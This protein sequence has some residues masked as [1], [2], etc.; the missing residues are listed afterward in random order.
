MD[1]RKT[2]VNYVAGDLLHGNGYSIEDALGRNAN[3]NL[4][5]TGSGASLSASKTIGVSDVHPTIESVEADLPAGE[6]GSGDEANFILTFDREISVA[7]IPKLPL[8]IRSS[9][10]A[11][12]VDGSGT[13]RLKFL[14]KVLPGDDVERLDISECTGAELL[15][16]SGDSIV[17]LINA[18]RASP[19]PA[20]TKIEGRTIYQRIAIDTTPPYVKGITPQAST[21]PSGTY[22]V[23]DKLFFE[24]IRKY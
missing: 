15:L 12:F 17:L 14:F 16:G 22:T 13:K 6:Y 2:E 3:L 7:G 5:A 1:I 19:L 10:A 4:P 8:N 9:R 11:I 24:V 18:P 23:G 20:N 21:T